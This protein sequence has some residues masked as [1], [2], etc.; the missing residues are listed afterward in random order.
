MP[1]DAR[2]LAHDAGLRR[3]QREELRGPHDLLDAPVENHAVM[4]EPKQPLLREHLRKGTVEQRAIRFCALPRAPGFCALP[5]AARFCARP[6]AGEFHPLHPV[7]FRR[8]RGRVFQ[9][10]RF[11]AGHQQLRGG[12]EGRDFALLL[13]AVV[14]A[15][16]LRHAHVR[17]LQLDHAERDAVHPDHHI[18]PPVAVCGN[19]APYCHFLGDGKG[20]F[21]RIYPVDEID[22][23]HRLAGL[24]G[25]R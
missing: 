23:L 8:E 6:R 20:V 3:L 9:P 12:E 13:V 10:F 15:D 14:L 19:L 24:R 22:L 7:L 2:L 18:G 16:A 17:L 11:V 4:D 21:E 5:R 25:D 1:D